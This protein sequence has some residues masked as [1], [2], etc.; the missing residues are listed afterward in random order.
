MC[1]GEVKDQ[2]KRQSLESNDEDF[3]SMFSNTERSMILYQTFESVEEVKES[4]DILLQYMHDSIDKI[5][6]DVKAQKENIKNIEST[7][8]VQNRKI[9]NL[10][11]TLHEILNI[12]KDKKEGL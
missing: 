8:E 12:L 9:E 11:S 6:N 10:N 4:S 2:D 5:T 1:P 3:A 7:I